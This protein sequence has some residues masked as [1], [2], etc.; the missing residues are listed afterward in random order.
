MPLPNR[1]RTSAGGSSVI[2][3]QHRDGARVLRKKNIAKT[4]KGK[5]KE[6]QVT[7]DMP[8]GQGKIVRQE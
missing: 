1:F 7:V 2:T 4:A 6:E 8:D 3:L 5:R